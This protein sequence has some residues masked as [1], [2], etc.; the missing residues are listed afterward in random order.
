MLFQIL[1]V[2]YTLVDERPIIRIFGKGEKG[3]T[4]CGFFEN[5]EP[6]IY[7][8]GEGVEDGIKDENNVVRIERVKRYLPL[9]YQKEMKD[10]HK[11]TLRNPAKT[12]EIRDRLVSRGFKVLEADI[13]FK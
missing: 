2:D 5:Y 6:Y 4:V 8:M 11:I 3:E 7:V 10:M 12:P 9:G 13:P 1:D